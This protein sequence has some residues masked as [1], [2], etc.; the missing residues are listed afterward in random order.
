[1]T[2]GVINYV[3]LVKGILEQRFGEKNKLFND[4][5][6]TLEICLYI[7]KSGVDGNDRLHPARVEDHKLGKE[8]FQA[9]NFY[10][11]KRHQ[12]ARKI[13]NKIIDRPPEISL[14]KHPSSEVG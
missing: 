1:M 7:I 8:L 10:I 4:P 2:S 13:I 14:E 12:E 5:I 9:L 3:E 11:N 6:T